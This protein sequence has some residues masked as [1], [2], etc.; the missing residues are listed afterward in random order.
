MIDPKWANI[1]GLVFDAVGAGVL[2]Y[3]LV[4][5]KSAAIEL[6][7]TRWAGD[8]DAENLKLP[9]VRDRLRQSRNA[10]IGMVLLIV[11]FA[12]QIYSSWPR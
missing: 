2:T 4:I 7:V 5:S 11:G 6:G 8:T 10:L 1:V 12:L 3:G 9:A